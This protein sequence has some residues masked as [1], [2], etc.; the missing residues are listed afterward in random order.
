MLS[1]SGGFHRETAPA[2][3][4]KQ[5]KLLPNERKFVPD[6]ISGDISFHLY[7]STFLT[8]QKYLEF[9]KNLEQSSSRHDF[10]F[11]V[12]DIVAAG[13]S[14]DQRSISANDLNNIFG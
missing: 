3:K 6:R 4:A 13:R 7:R 11:W 14:A 12:F 9:L 1:K 10:L 2:T 8:P 5:F